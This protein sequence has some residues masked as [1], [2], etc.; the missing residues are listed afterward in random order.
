MTLYT[1]FHGTVIHSISIK[2]LDISDNTLLVIDDKGKIVDM[3]RDIYDIETYL[4]EHKYNHCKIH[5]LGEDQFIIPGFVDTHAHAPQYMFAGCGMDLPLLDWLNTYVFP[6][7]SSFEDKGHAIQAYQKVIKRFLTN[8]TTTCSWFGTIHLE[9]SKV[10][11]DIVEQLGQRAFIG[12]VNMDQNSPDYYIED[13]KSSLEDTRAFI[14]YVQGKKS[15]LVTPVITPRFAITCSSTLMKGLSELATEYN[16]PIQ[17]HL[18]E[19]KNEISFTQSL[20]ECKDYTSVYNDHALLNERAYMAHC[21]HMTEDEIDMLA[22]TKTGV[23]H[24][25][26]SNFSLHSGICDIRKFLNKGVKVG[27]GTDVAGGYSPSMLDAIRST[28]IAS[29]TLK[30]LNQG[31]E[32]EYSQLSTSELFFLSTLGGAQVMGLDGVIG[33]FKQGKSFDAI[34]VDLNTGSVDMMGGETR[35]QK[36]E[37]FM[38]NGNDQNIRDVYVKGRRVS[39]SSK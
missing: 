26:N 37:K 12:K 35:L 1:V 17:T 22:H 29:K 34:V 30:I 28:F 9:S 23:A 38:F 15:D 19:N 20:F 21:V 25:A 36:L 14:D 5:K 31:Q 3:A 32:S 13:T 16:V 33:N 8:G 24:C 6:C 39:G 27:L 11:V 2:E 7:E 4:T 18:C 10:L